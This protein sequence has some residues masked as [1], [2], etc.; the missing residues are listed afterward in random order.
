[1][2]KVMTPD[3]W[4]VRRGPFDPER[5]KNEDTKSRIALDLVV[6]NAVEM[7]KI[8][9]HLAPNNSCY[10]FMAARALR[11]PLSLI[12]VQTPDHFIFTRDNNLP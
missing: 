3:V 8:P 4:G 5:A 12:S 10:P 11:G 1:M 2:K 6:P 9:R 7:R